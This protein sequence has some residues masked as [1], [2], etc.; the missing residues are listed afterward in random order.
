MASCHRPHVTCAVLC[1]ITV[2]WLGN[3]DSNGDNND[4]NNNENDN[5]TGDN[6]KGISVNP[7]RDDIVPLLIHREIK[8]NESMSI[9]NEEVVPTLGVTE[10][11]TNTNHLSIIDG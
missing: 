9:Q 10:I 5:D 6:M 1:R 4:T 8:K 2:A 11:P 7:Y 3:G